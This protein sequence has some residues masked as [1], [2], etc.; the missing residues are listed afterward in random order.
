MKITD[1][2]ADDI[3]SRD[4]GMFERGVAAA[5]AGAKGGVTQHEFDAL[6]DLAFNIGLG[7]FKSSSLLRAYRAG[8]KATAA[9]KFLDWNKAGGRVVPGLTARRKRERAWFLMGDLPGAS[10]PVTQAERPL[11]PVAALPAPADV[12]RK[13]NPP[14]PPLVRFA[15]WLGSLFA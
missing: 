13:M 14:D 1:A 3:L 12:A 5:V 10:A 15:N 11:A 6:V 8:D 9:R 4:L 2:E 7:A